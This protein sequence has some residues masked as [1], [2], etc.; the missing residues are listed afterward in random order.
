M[1]RFYIAATMS[2]LFIAHLNSA[3]A[4]AM[5]EECKE[6]AEKEGFDPKGCVCLV[7]A[8]QQ[9]AELALEIAELAKL[10]TIEDRKNAASAEALPVIEQ[11]FPS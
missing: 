7:E 10:P 5:L 6:Q 11:C 9:N 1:R 4:Q 3:S 2:G 8:V